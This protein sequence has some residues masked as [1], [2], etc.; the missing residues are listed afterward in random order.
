MGD[1][2][3]V[4][5]DLLQHIVITPTHLF[6]NTPTPSCDYHND[7]EWC[8]SHQYMQVGGQNSNNKANQ[9]K[10]MNSSSSQYSNPFSTTLRSR[11]T[12]SN[13]SKK[14]MLTPS[15]SDVLLSDWLSK[16]RAGRISVILLSDWLTNAM[17]MRRLQL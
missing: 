5:T 3:E 16:V 7:H 15:R 8:R 1:R 9:W 4:S 17:V 12:T 11:I 13:N 2:R 6:T 10:D 14:K